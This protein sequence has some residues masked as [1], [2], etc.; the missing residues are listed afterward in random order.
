MEGTIRG[1]STLHD[2]ESQITKIEVKGIVQTE[3]GLL[4]SF[5]DVEVRI[6]VVSIKSESGKKMDQKTS[7]PFNLLGLMDKGVD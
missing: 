2:W 7:S 5:R 3:G 1:T 6:P 4:V